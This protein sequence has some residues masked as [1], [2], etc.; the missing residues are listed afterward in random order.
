MASNKELTA[1]AEELA[2][3]L[4]VAAETDGC[5]ECRAHASWIARAKRLT[6][7]SGLATGGGA[8]SRGGVQGPGN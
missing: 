5:Q 3:A 6:G 8:A 2:A 7:R 4:G 1:Q